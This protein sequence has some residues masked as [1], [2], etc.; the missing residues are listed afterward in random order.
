M[1]GRKTHLNDDGKAII[2]RRSPSE[3]E[4]LQRGIG[5]MFGDVFNH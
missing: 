1:V 2:R 5:E 4:E 3:A